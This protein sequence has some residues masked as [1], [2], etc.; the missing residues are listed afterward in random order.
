MNFIVKNTDHHLERH[1]EIE[2]NK[3]YFLQLINVSD[4]FYKER[5]FHCLNL[6]EPVELKNMIL[7]EYGSHS[8]SE[9][10]W[11][12]KER[13]FTSFFRE[14][15]VDVPRCFRK[16]LSVRRAN[17]EINLLKL[18]NY[19]MRN[20]QRISVFTNLS[21]ILNLEFNNPIYLGDRIIKTTY[22]WRSIFIILNSSLRFKTNTFILPPLK[23]TTT[24]YNNLISP[25][26]KDILPI[27]DQNKWI[28]KNLY[29][30]LPI[31]SFYIY[32]VD[33]KIFKNTRGKS[34]KF[35]FIWKYV[36]SY[37][38]MFLVMHWLS[39]ELKI[40]PGRN[41]KERLTTLIQTIT[42]SPELTWIFKVK[43]FSHNY[44]YR[45]SRKTLAENYRSV[46]K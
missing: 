24:P 11:Y 7:D 13:T 44:I 32:K 8:S 33:K 40:K 3:N 9:N 36:T 34:G 37:K 15:N 5:F 41:F 28:F 35:T 2:T 26:T 46:T 43:K 6:S 21:S 16:T 45:N 39:K 27:W 25:I 31:F 19:I 22:S 20:G 23:E 29:N 42:S 38:R 17:N 12:L 1:Y 14:N 18:N 10:F 4:E 30:L